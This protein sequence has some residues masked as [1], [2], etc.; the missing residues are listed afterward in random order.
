MEEL[1]KLYLPSEDTT[2]EA[3]SRDIH[4]LTEE[5]QK[6]VR[7]MAGYVIVS[8]RR[9]LK[10]SSHPQKE[11]LIL[12]L[13]NLCEDSNSSDTFLAYTKSWIDK[14]D[15]GGLFPVNDMTYS[16][17]EVIEIELRKYYS[18][19]QIKV[20]PPIQEITILIIESEDVQFYWC[21]LSAELEDQNAQEL[22]QKIIHLWITIRGFSFAKSVLEQYKQALSLHTSKKRALRKDIQ[23]Q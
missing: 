7:Y 5:E 16:L 10:H 19:N 8:L 14:L 20:L 6:V 11:E 15:H 1:I 23:V 2:A 18:I 4:Q 12:C 22:L 17:F 21:L 13:W 3:T 9:K